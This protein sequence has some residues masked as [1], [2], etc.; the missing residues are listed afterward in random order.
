MALTT[1][2]PVPA[3]VAIDLQKGIVSGGDPALAAA[4]AQ[5]AQLA[6]GF[7][8]H[9]LPVVLVT[10]TASAP[11]RREVG[12][13]GAGDPSSAQWA[14]IVDELTVQPT[15]HLIAKRRYSAFHDTGL[16]TLLR[17]LGVTQVVVAG[18]TTSSAI[19]SS[20]RSAADYGFHVVVATDAIYDP[21]AEAHRHSV[22]R[23][24]PKIGETAATADVLTMLE[25]TR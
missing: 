15:D 21:D 22:Q 25:A 13:R 11:G 19:E 7:R 9:G 17:D 10:V 5:A 2:D 1:I 18:V 12:R 4:V 6:A 3:L 14:E 16:S 20:A 8:R 24:F 23:I